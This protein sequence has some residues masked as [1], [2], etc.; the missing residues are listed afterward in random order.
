M[1][2]IGRY[3]SFI[4][5][6]LILLVIP[7]VGQEVQVTN[8]LTGE[9]LLNATLYSEKPR[10]IATSNGNGI[11]HI[12]AMKGSERIEIR[13][14]GYRTEYR[15][16]AMIEADSFRVMLLPVSFNLDKI[17][18]SA[19]RWSQSSGDIPARVSTIGSDRVAMLNP[20]SA[21]D[22]LAVSG[23]VFVQ[24]SQQG[25]GSP[26]IRGFSSNRLLY[27]VDGV[28]M[29]TAIFRSGNL[30][31]VISLDPFAIENTEVYFGPG[32]VIYGS[33]AIGGV[34]SFQ[35]LTPTFS[36]DSTPV[37]SGRG[38]G[39]YASAN[40]E[41]TA[42]YDVNVGWKRFAMVTSIT[43]SDFSDLRMGRHGPDEYL[44]TFFV[45]RIDSVDVM[46]ENSDPLVQTPSGYSQMNIMQK[47][48]FMP[49][50][51]WDIQ[52][53]FHFSETSHFS[54]YDRH[55]AVRDN[56]PRFA[57][58]S[59][60]PQKWL[61]HNLSVYH[62][63]DGAAF[64][65]MNIRL[66]WQEF[67]ESR[68]T[69]RFNDLN[70]TIRTENV[71]ALSANMDFIRSVG[72][73]GRI[74]YGVEA[75]HN[76]V[77][78]MGIMQDIVTVENIPAAPRYPMASWSSAAIYVTGQWRF[79]DQL[80]VQGG[81][82]QSH[83]SMD[84]R[85]DT[86]F[87]PL[88]FTNASVQNGSLTGS[89]GLVYRPTH[90]W[91]ISA[92][93]ATGFRAPNVDDMGKLFDPV[94]GVVVVPN[95]NLLAEYVYS[96]DLELARVFGQFLKLDL[97]IYY[98]LLDNVLVRRDYTFN[99]LDSM[100]Y[101][102]EMSRVQAI[103]NGAVARVGGVQA[104]MELK[105]P[106][107]FRFIAD[108]NYQKGVEELDDG[109]TSPSRHAPPWFG[110][111][112]LMWSNSVLKLEFYSMFS[113]AKSF[114]QLPFEERDKTD[115]YAIDN[116][117]NPW[118]P[119]WYTLNFNASQKITD[120]FTLSAG[121]LNITDQRYRTYSSGITAPGRSFIISFTASM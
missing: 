16:Y 120:H 73:S 93:L 3:I 1:L 11:A 86:T 114:E 94:P 70:R 62:T 18:V 65:Q 23:K 59:Y 15:S 89:A 57:E 87:H 98:T 48:R 77:S 13:M 5:I 75:I 41:I 34:M 36:R 50:N 32:S 116:N 37:V 105:L 69:R 97:S 53:G 64:D 2:E 26:M 85:F 112:R 22:L 24:K 115:L 90:N 63:S 91:V 31:N 100:M 96:A 28:R 42:H 58:W 111:G 12:G 56:Q 40:N 47:L 117:G 71:T 9:P 39:R 78:S 45:Q 10:S 82:R 95:P 110:N 35:T 84:A 99:G 43:T 8:V 74:Y 29:N 121:I 19:S 20:Q 44:R 68:I 60:G 92:N 88:P 61:M 118:S 14:M 109:T 38:V 7:A 76:D 79:S 51:A 6:S 81:I 113:G 80:L 33:D 66:A 101:D 83:F 54:R 67:E 17:V 104:G 102:G 108:I 25:G 46:T 103:Q 4:F 52:Y 119:G 72:S 21:A 49:T 106:A 107:G 30:H 55:L 27:T